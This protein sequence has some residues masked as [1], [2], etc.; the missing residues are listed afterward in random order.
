[1]FNK[2]DSF[3]DDQPGQKSVRCPELCSVPVGLREHNYLNQILCHRL[4]LAL[5]SVPRQDR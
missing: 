5:I 2:F 3:F 4:I 1:M